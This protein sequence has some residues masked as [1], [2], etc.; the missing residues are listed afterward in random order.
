[1]Y[2]ESIC[3]NIQKND[4]ITLVDENKVVG[5]Y[6]ATKIFTSLGL[7]KQEIESAQNGDIIALAGILELTIGQTI[8]DPAHS[9]HSVSLPKIEIEEPTIKVTIGPNTSPFAGRE[10]KLHSSSQIKD[11]L[12]QEKEINF[13]LRIEH[14]T[15]SANFSV[16][17]RGELHLAVLI[18]TMRRE[19]FELEVTKPQVI[20]KT[21]DGIECEPYEE[22][23]IDV[24]NEFTGSITEELAKRKGE[25]LHMNPERNNTMRFVYKISSKNLLGIRNALLT[26]TCGTAIINTFF[27]GYF[28]RID[29][30]E[31]ARNGVLVAAEAG[32]ALS[33]GLANVQE[34]GILFIAPGT[35]V[36]EGMIVGISSRDADLDINVCKEKK[37]TNMRSSTGDISVQI[38]PP[39]IL[40]LAQALDFI[41]EDE[42]LEVT[43]QNIRLRKR[44]LSA[45]QRRV[46]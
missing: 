24:D 5:T 28:P 6:R 4:A 14:G 46:Q 45:T 3:W 27:L 37:Q 36:Y 41:N 39:T 34:R 38:T 12:L 32:Q 7:N 11:R 2:W 25:M 35:P 16:A 23:T 26:K 9:V 22:A 10:G 33:Y 40:S 44:F 31:V 1:L 42:I 20:Y 15:D 17:G 21:I 29:R 8:T 43:P 19:G 18:E 30:M 13:G